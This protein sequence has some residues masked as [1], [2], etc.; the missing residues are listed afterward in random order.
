[1]IWEEVLVQLSKVIDVDKEKCVKC[2]ACI[3]ACPVKYCNNIT[4]NA[5]E[6][7]ENLCIGCGN[8]ITA[9][10]HNARSGIDDFNRFLNDV[11]QGV[12]FVAIVAPSV[13]SS[14]PGKYL[15]LNGWLKTSGVDAVFDVSFGA[16]LT[17]KS[18]IDY[19]KINKPKAVIAQ[20]CPAIVSYIEIYKPELIEYL[21]PAD[22]PMLHTITMIKN[23][24]PEYKD[25]LTAVISPC[26][27]KRRELDSTG[28]GDKAYNIT[29]R[30]LDNY[31]K[32]N[33][34][35][36]EN[37]KN[38]NFNNPSAE[39]GVLF[40]T[41]GGLL[42]TVE[43]DYPGVWRKTRR[44]EGVH[45]VYPYLQTFIDSISRNVNPLLLDCLN[46]SMGC[47]GGPGSLVSEMIPDQVEHLVEER[48]IEMQKK[49]K[50]AGWN[51]S[52]GK[53]NKVLAP[54]W[55]SG[56]YKRK[57]EDCSSNNIIRLPDESQLKL[58]WEDMLKESDEDFLDCGACGYR[59]CKDMA[60]AVF[61]NLNRRESCY[62]YKQKMILIE[63]NKAEENNRQ[64]LSALE[65]ANR[66]REKFKNEYMN[67]IK[68][69]QSISAASEEV[70]ANNLSVSE[71][72]G[73]LF[74]LSN[75][76][77]NAL[78]NLSEIIKD[79]DTLSFELLP[80]ADSINEIADRT[81][82]LSLNAAIEAAR[83]G[84]SGRGFAVVSGEIKKL[85]E[86]TQAEVKK[87]EPFAYEI[88]KAHEKITNTFRE[89]DSQFDEIARI[90][91]EV[92]TA[93]EEM[94]AAMAEIN[95][96][97]EGLGIVRDL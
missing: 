4:G 77:K 58:I 64:A 12:R 86:Y 48:N 96:E 23:F 75:E 55:K 44:I 47:N 71:M 28:L 3:T 88:K 90:T 51:N 34:I 84:E 92:T 97:I 38:E 56:L 53:V 24:Y 94:T 19:I 26:Y 80:I 89:V 87:I 16:E 81:D 67:K 49:Y 17:V 30:S 50:T 6:I 72:A 65:D 7:N 15:N 61:N 62:I 10:T 74:R 14:F 32:N 20:P 8:C 33:D 52:S 36:L 93:T 40:S 73:R 78:F 42:A 79:A 31:F 59:L 95:S 39:R 54:Y 66:Q 1:L 11:K 5:V 68:L 43:R 82:L 69:A 63:H 13:A 29:Y 70:E 18:Y 2:H 76:Q 22:S 21:A 83:A 45:S 37:Y 85:A 57:Y 60:V 27:A 35:K 91:A 25:Y 41:P 9:C 46:C